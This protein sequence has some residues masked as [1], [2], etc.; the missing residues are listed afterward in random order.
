MGSRTGLGA[1]GLLVAVAIGGSELASAQRQ[2]PTVTA[3]DYYFEAPD[4]SRTP[5]SVTIVPGGAVSFDYPVGASQH[6]VH[7]LAGPA[8]PSCTG[9]NAISQ[10]PFDSAGR[11]ATPQGPGWSGTCAFSTPGDYSFNCTLHPSTMYGTVHVG[12]GPSSGSGSGNPAT[13]VRAIVVPSVQHGI[14]VTGTVTLAND[15]SK[16]VVGVYAAHSLLAVAHSVLVGETVATALPAG[17]H[18]FR[19]A[20]NGAA[21][22][23]LRRHR[24]LALK[25]KLSVSAGSQPAVAVTRHLTLTA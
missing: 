10:A 3:H 22:R 9:A 12:S 19:V 4:G 23:A 21:R 14:A 5:A 6:D 16:L 20:L 1:A 13:A 25:V 18:S 2:A 24:R 15:G 7:F 8:A 17:R 11:S